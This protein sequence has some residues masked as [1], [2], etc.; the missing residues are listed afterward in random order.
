MLATTIPF[1]FELQEEARTRQVAPRDA[2]PR[3]RP[4]RSAA[5][6]KKP[7]VDLASDDDGDDD[8]YG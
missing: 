8:D 3:V 4:G 7:V 6:K 1:L 5:M 2:A